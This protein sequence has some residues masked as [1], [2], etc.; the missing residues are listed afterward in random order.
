MRE[1][2]RTRVGIIGGG[3]LGMMLTEAAA[4]LGL[5]VAVLDQPG[6]PATYA[7][8]RLVPGSI[9][10]ADRIRELARG[11]DVVTFEIEHVNTDALLEIEAQGVTVHPSPRSLVTIKDK[12]AQKTF[13]RGHG[14][15]TADFLPVEGEADLLQAAARFGFPFLVKTRHGGFDGRGNAV[16][17]TPSDFAGT[18]RK[19][20]G[21]ALYAERFVPF[22]R[23]LAVMVTRSTGGE[24]A[25]YPVVETVHEESV[26][27]LV[28]APAPIDPALAHRA[29]TLAR[30][31]MGHLHGAGVFGIEMFLTQDG[32]ILI[33]EIAPR[34][35]NS[36]HYT[37]EACAT[38]QFAQHLL[39]I[40]GRPLGPT[41]MTY[42]AAVMVNILGARSG[43]A[44][45]R[46]T[47]AAGARGEAA[48]HWYH[49]REVRPLRKMGHITVTG[50]TVEQCL[51]TATAARALVSA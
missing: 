48:V 5:D 45:Q 43:V 47:E 26:L 3:Q 38:S 14:I 9:T 34:V 10:D 6:C 25:T 19:L 29:E 51:E 27:R 2:A 15:P 24:I 12:F 42:P 1:E 41:T 28:L 23:E 50:D 17:A 39:A 32:E 31:V 16:V 30:D 18:L 22:A 40:T 8:A 4:P 20:G 11:V 13:L 33:N 21:A 44:D 49:K 37:I 36:G 46:G 7:G 35:H